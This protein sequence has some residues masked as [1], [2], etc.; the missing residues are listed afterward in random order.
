MKSTRETLLSLQMQLAQ[1]E[2]LKRERKNKR[3]TNYTRNHLKGQPKRELDLQKNNSEE[4]KDLL[5]NTGR[6]IPTDHRS[7]EKH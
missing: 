7:N 1:N 4:F 2:C 5:L 6:K 3:S